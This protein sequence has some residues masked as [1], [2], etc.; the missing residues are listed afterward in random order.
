[1]ENYFPRELF[2]VGIDFRSIDFRSIDFRSIDFRSPLVFFK[3]LIV[4][5]GFYNICRKNHR[6][7]KFRIMGVQL[8]LV[9]VFS[10]LNYTT[11]LQLNSTG[12]TK[13]K[14]LG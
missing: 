2:S 6:L 13:K 5:L 9:T 12:Y 3:F 1:M 10:H 14:D 8:L 11:T 7:N 4:S